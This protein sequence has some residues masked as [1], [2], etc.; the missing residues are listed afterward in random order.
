MVLYEVIL[1]KK[2]HINKC[3]SVKRYIAARIVMFQDN[4]RYYMVSVPIQLA[5][6]YGK[7]YSLVILF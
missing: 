3:L 2:C 1:S 4:L 7:S 6:I 5:A